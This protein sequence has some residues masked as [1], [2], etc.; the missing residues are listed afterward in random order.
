MTEQNKIFV[1]IK[2]ILSFFIK[3]DV[4]AEK[5]RSDEAKREMCRK[6]VQANVCPNSCEICAWNVRSE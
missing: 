6:A 5:R 1:F 4:E 2:R 3:K